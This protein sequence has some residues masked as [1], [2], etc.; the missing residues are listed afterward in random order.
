MQRGPY[1]SATIAAIG[2][3]V[4]CAIT[5]TSKAADDNFF[6]DKVEPLLQEKCLTCHSHSDRQMEGGLTLD[7]RA[8]WATGGDRGPAIVPGDL[9]AS[10]LIQ[11]IR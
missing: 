3:A 6:Q 11:A 5:V 10:L 8:G 2:I 9:V 1:P 4:S 7:S